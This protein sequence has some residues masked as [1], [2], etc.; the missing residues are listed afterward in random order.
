MSRNEQSMQAERLLFDSD[1]RTLSV[2]LLATSLGLFFIWCAFIVGVRSKIIPATICSAL[3]ILMLAVWIDRWQIFYAPANR[4][5]ILRS[6]GTRRVSLSGVD[7]VIVKEVKK[8]G[9]MFSAGPYVDISLRYSDGRGWLISRQP[10]GDP[11]HLA[12]IISE[13]IGLP[14]IHERVGF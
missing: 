13:A 14:I 7:A 4:Q 3:G 11:K 8:G 6:W 12:L 2:K 1:S 10:H 5:L 9:G